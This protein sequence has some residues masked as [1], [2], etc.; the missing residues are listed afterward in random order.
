MENCTRV[1][2][3]NPIQT[4][5]TIYDFANNVYTGSNIIAEESLKILEWANN[6]FQRYI[7]LST[8]VDVKLHRHSP[9]QTFGIISDFANIL[10]RT[11]YAIAEK[12]LKILERANNNVQR[13][14]K[15]STAV[16]EKLHYITQ[17][18]HTAVCDV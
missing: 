10:Y 15:L 3:F 2:L 17:Y 6:K 13:Y 12:S 4:Y 16:D 14:I 7:K 11:F 18:E 8:P 1:A 5:S 9:R